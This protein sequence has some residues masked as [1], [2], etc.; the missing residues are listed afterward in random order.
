MSPCWDGEQSRM[1]DG[2]H[3]PAGIRQKQNQQ[4]LHYII[5]PTC[6]L[7]PTLLPRL[8]TPPGQVWTL[9]VSACSSALF[10]PLEIT[11][12]EQHEHHPWSVLPS[13]RKHP[14]SLQDSTEEALFSNK[15]GLY[16]WRQGRSRC[17]VCSY[18]ME[19]H[20]LQHSPES[21]HS[22][23]ILSTRRWGAGVQRQS[24]PCFY[25]QS[26]TMPLTESGK[27]YFW[28]D[29]WRKDMSGTDVCNQLYPL[30]ISAPPR[31]S[32]TEWVYQ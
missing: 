26:S 18:R 23:F 11:T 7:N 8:L 30:L 21:A 20:P 3:H 16:F 32:D 24:C 1:G 17:P 27:K 9:D 25:L 13:P 22:L 14:L 31:T 29:Q 28:L 15:H 6:Y 4:A 5:G 19:T 12:E 2:S 10:P